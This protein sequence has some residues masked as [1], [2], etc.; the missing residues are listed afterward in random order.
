MDENNIFVYFV[1]VE[2]SLISCLLD[3]ILHKLT[4]GY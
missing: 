1:N 3:D 2:V 4:N